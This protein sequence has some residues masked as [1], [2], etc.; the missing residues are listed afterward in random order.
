MNLTAREFDVLWLLVQAQ[1]RAVSRSEFL[2][3]VWDLDFDP[4]TNSL[5]VH[6]SRLRRKLSPGSAARIETV[7]GEGYRVVPQNGPTGKA[8]SG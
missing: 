6:I 2:H 5:Q 8:A 4:E 3:R 1:G 7:R